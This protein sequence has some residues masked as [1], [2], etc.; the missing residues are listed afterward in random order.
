MNDRDTEVFTRATALNGDK[1]S[2]TPERMR[3]YFAP[4]ERN[5][6]S[7]TGLDKPRTELLVQ[8]RPARVACLWC[9]ADLPGSRASGKMRRAV[10]HPANA[11]GLRRS[12]RRICL[13]RRDAVSLTL[14]LDDAVAE[15]GSHVTALV[16]GPSGRFAVGWSSLTGGAQVVLLEDFDEDGHVDL[17]VT[18]PQNA[19]SLFPGTGSATF[20]PRSLFPLG[21]NPGPGAVSADFDGDGH[22]DIGATVRGPGSE[23][24]KLYRTPAAATG[25][26]Y[27][28]V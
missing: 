11:G 25:S 4:L 12:S 10:I 17:G 5:P 26:K 19:V 23:P 13:G 15:T 1:Q 22:A 27:S 18:G 20:D 6:L 9:K 28:G 3:P 16:A 14:H 8:G 24:L 7:Q 21:G 2:E